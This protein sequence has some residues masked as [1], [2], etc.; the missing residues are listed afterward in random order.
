MD[1]IIQSDQDTVSTIARKIGYKV[2]GGEPGGEFNLVKSITGY[3]YPRFHI[4]IKKDEKYNEF[5]FN[6]HI[7]QKQPS[8]PG[9]GAHAH[10]GDYD[11]EVV[12]AEAERIKSFF[13]A[14]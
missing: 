6:L 8:Y 4:Y 11:G 12:E 3:R 10:S 13:I 14:E 2:N 5:H 9:S 1:F 7:D